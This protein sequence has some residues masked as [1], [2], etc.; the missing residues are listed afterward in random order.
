MQQ[1]S[2]IESFAVKLY[3]LLDAQLLAID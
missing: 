2:R 1:Q 3:I